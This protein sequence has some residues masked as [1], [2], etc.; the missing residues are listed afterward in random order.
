MLQRIQTVY[1]TIALLLIASPL[2]GLEL[3]SVKI[4]EL[5]G[6]TFDVTPFAILSKGIPMQMSVLWIY[7]VI[8]VIAVLL[9][10][11]TFKSR[12]KQMTLAKMSIALVILISGWLIVSGYQFLS[13]SEYPKN[14]G[15][16]LGIGFY[17]FASSII[18]LILGF[19]GVR[20]DKKLIDSV[21][22]IR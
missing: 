12:E 13:K 5:G 18:F 16:I 1:F 9:T 8:P 4:D 21:D 22:R 14:H 10:I 3:F 15:V 11:F 7:C 2:L 20:K 17:L 6:N 19:R